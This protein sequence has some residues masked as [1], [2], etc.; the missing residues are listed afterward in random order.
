MQDKYFIIR[1][2]VKS[3]AEFTETLLC[4]LSN[5]L[6][7]C[8]LKLNLYFYCDSMPFIAIFIFITGVLNCECCVLHYTNAENSQVSVFRKLFISIFIPWYATPKTVSIPTR[9]NVYPASAFHAF[10]ALIHFQQPI[11]LFPLA[12]TVFLCIIIFILPKI[13]STFE[14]RHF[15]VLRP[16]NEVYKYGKQT[17]SQKSWKIFSEK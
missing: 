17:R 5:G 6:S 8:F 13:S 4:N 11:H 15:L 14:P 9:L 2:I 3:L 7:S 1:Q 10:I 12:T 16:A